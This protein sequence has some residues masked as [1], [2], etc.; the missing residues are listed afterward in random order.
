MSRKS[1]HEDA[2]KV[3]LGSEALYGGRGLS[4]DIL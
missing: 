3:A 2:R 4:K 1:K